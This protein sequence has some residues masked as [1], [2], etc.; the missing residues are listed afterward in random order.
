MSILIKVWSLKRRQ[1]AYT[2]G[3]GDG[4]Q[5]LGLWWVSHDEVQYLFFPCDPRG[6]KWCL[7]M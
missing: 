2:G 5:G 1:I 7:C 3:V 6:A 4:V